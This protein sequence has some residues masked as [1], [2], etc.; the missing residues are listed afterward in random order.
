MRRVACDDDGSIDCVQGCSRDRLIDGSA[1]P[2]WL[3]LMRRS[4]VVRII[5]RRVALV[6]FSSSGSS[7]EEQPTQPT[8]V[9]GLSLWA[10]AR[11][12]GF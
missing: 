9:R 2:P 8:L 4:C 6:A 1:A 11:L 7:E 3:H 10:D 12:D 5:H